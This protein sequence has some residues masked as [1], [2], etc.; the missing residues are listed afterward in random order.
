MLVPGQELAPTVT[1]GTPLQS[2]AERTRI[3]EEW[4]HA[5]CIRCWLERHTHIG[6]YCSDREY[7]FKKPQRPWDL[8]LEPSL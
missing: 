6:G 7:M 1:F 5:V 3:Y 4:V 2:K 8:L